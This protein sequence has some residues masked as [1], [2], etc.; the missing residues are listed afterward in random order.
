MLWNLAINEYKKIGIDCVI[1][2][3]GKPSDNYS[4]EKDMVRY[5]AF[6]DFFRSLE[7]ECRLVKV[8]QYQNSLVKNMNPFL[9]P[10]IKIYS[11]QND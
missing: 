7:G 9:N 2:V 5:P 11:L 8:F 3:R 1:V 10:E 4:S 6:Y